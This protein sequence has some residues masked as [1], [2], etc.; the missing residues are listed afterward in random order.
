MNISGKCFCGKISVKG[1]VDITDTFA[2]HCLDCR[3]FSGAPFR[4]VVKCKKENF[5]IKGNP[6]EYVKIGGSGK[7]R[8]QAFCEVC[9]SQIFASDEEKSLINIR[10]GFLNQ[11]DMLIPKKHIFSHCAID[12]IFKFDDHEWV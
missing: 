6:A 9:G 11:R 12:W 3:I 1:V 4:V 7:K 5:N 10:V 2:C 8:I